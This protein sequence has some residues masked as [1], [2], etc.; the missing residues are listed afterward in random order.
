MA[1][2]R[3][4]RRCGGLTNLAWSGDIGRYSHARHQGCEVL[5][6]GLPHIAA[7]Q[8]AKR[9]RAATSGAIDTEDS[10]DRTAKA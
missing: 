6:C 9:S 5:T 3:A 1:G 10:P 7:H 8:R 2:R 4:A